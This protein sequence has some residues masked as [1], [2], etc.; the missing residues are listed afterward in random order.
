MNNHSEKIIIGTR[1][2]ELA[3]WQANFTKSE[4]EKNGFEVEIKIIKTRGDQIQHLS[5]DKIEGKGFFTKELEEELLANEIDLAVHSCKDLPSENPTGLTI[6]A[7]SDRA[8]PIDVLL[9]NKAKINPNGLLKIHSNAL[10]G[11]SSSRRKAQ[12]SAHLPNLTI[13]DIRGNVPTRINKL[14]N[15]EFDAIILAAAGIERLNIDISDLERVDLS[16]PFFIPAAAQ[17]VLAFQIRAD[18]ERS[19]KIC[20]TLH[21]KTA[22]KAIL[23]ER[24]ILNAFNGG[25]QIPLAIHCDGENLWISKAEE[26]FSLPKRIRINSFIDKNIDLK[27]VALQFNQINPKTV[28]IS[29]ENNQDY[30]FRTLESHNYQVLSYSL[31]NFTSSNFTIENDFDWVFFSSKK[32]VDFFMS[33]IDKSILETKKIAAIG[34]ETAQY[35]REQY[36]LKVDFIADVNNLEA[37]ITQFLKTNP[38]KVL[39]PRGKNSMESIQRFLP[40]EMILEVIVYCNE[41]KANIEKIGA[42]LLIFTSPLNAKTYFSSHALDTH[43]QCIAIGNSTKHALEKMKIECNTAF[44]PSPWCLVDEVFGSSITL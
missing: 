4:L 22:E 11:T 30:F 10:V 23:A 41:P 8:N 36:H 40:S 2:S 18:D 24:Q 33:G 25:C 15:G 37:S 1:G 34:V 6:G 14:R 39:L 42:E 27:T 32:G 9:I 20:K 17:G 13:K 38:Q 3:L 35:I 21:T 16:P 29:R 12:I 43:Q 26:S 44:N 31:L 5:F 7:Y 19:L 28:F